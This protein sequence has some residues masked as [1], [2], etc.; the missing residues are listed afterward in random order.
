M[1]TVIGTAIKNEHVS[2]EGCKKGRKYETKLKIF[3]IL[4]NFIPNLDPSLVAD[5]IIQLSE[6]I[7][8]DEVLNSNADKASE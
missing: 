1:E 3:C 4:S 8:H 5:T 7:P 2:V 6:L